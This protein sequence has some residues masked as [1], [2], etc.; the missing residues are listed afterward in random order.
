MCYAER[1][2]EKGVRTYDFEGSPLIC[3]E[4]LEGHGFVW[5]K[6][7]E[8]SRNGDST[9]VRDKTGD[10]DDDSDQQAP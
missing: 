10:D 4:C 8:P 9:G 1:E 5:Y 6:L 3:A 7:R 2:D